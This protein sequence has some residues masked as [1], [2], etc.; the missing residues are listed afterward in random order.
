MFTHA[1][2]FRQ[3]HD[4]NMPRCGGP[5]NRLKNSQ[6]AALDTPRFRPEDSK[7]AGEK[8]SSILSSTG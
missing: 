5:A 3:Y 4:E 6:P 8:H 7:F 2:H 1:G